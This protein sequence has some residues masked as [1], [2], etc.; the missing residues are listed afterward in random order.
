LNI[1]I[2]KM[3]PLHIDEVMIVEHL[4]FTIPWSK[5]SFL[6]EITNNK[7]ALYYVAKVNGK[8][9]GYAG[10][11][12]IYSEGHITNIAVH[13]EFQSNKI[14]SLLLNYL[15]NEADILNIESM[16]LEVRR[17]NTAAL[18]L[19]SKYGFMVEGFRKGYYADNGE[20]ALIMW[21]RKQIP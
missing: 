2:E 6:E 9:Y 7:F 4:C 5:E 12:N 16:T 21:R 17:S 20:D 15:I 10:M 13:P 3:L 18:G 8:V 14:G 1:E 11:W 19:Y